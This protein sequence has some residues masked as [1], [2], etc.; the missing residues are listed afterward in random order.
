MFKDI[1][2][3]I[4]KKLNITIS[5]DENIINT[6]WRC[7]SET[8]LILL[9]MIILFFILYKLTQKIIICLALI[10]ILTVPSIKIQS[11]I[12]NTLK[13]YKTNKIKQDRK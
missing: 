8:W 6:L 1:L 5:N 11:W 12:N 13:H 3:Y 7:I 10:I 2:H 4:L 9:I